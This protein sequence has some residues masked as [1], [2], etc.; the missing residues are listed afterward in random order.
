MA[1]RR[2]LAEIGVVLFEDGAFERL[3]PLTWLRPAH[4]L[5]L[6]TRT[7]AARWR[8][9]AG[10]IVRAE[11]GGS[12]ID[13]GACDSGPDGAVVLVNGRLIAPGGADS[14]IAPAA[15]TKW[16][17]GEVVLAAA[18]PAGRVGE[19]SHGMSGVQRVCAALR[20]A[21]APAGLELIDHPWQLALRN[22]EQIRR[23]FAAFYRAELSGR[24]RAGA[25]LVAT[26][27][28]F[29]GAD[30]D[31]RPGAVLDAEAGP[32][33]VERGALVQSN[34][35]LEGPCFVGAGSIVR[36]GASIREGTTIGPVCKVGGEVEASILHGYANKQHDG[37]LGHSYVCP[38]V[39]LGADT[40]TSDLKN[41]YGTIR[42]F[43]NG[44]GVETGERFV[45]SIIGDHAKAGIGTILPTGC[46][47]G[48]AANIFTP[49]SVPKFV[50]SFSWVTDA[51][52][53]PFRVDKAI[54]IARTVMARRRV[55]LS[56]LEAERLARVCEDARR[57]EAGG[58]D[59][60]QG[61]SG[62]GS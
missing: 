47:V 42:V 20:E 51:G 29:V 27:R 53:A 16:T 40:V 41:T 24:V 6:G 36:A 34:A 60:L 62:G 32:V 10:T 45:G 43:L 59:S 17:R 4:D 23:D 33:I 18:V 7:L 11:L 3:L 49:G 56:A 28:I 44:V 54:E 55:E 26:E 15:G 21:P 22:A 12:T 39:N 52:V 9:V 31:I 2:T 46:V 5:M 37:F 38:W 48:V 13:A 57:V 35:V 61:A 30:A 50:P 14:C 25:H 19:L 1:Q 58:W 8:R